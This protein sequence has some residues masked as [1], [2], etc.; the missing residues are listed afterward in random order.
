MA[1]MGR[2]Y[3]AT[4]R[5]TMR[6]GGEWPSLSYPHHL[7]HG[8]RRLATLSLGK[9]VEGLSELC[10][11][12]VDNPEFVEAQDLLKQAERVLSLA[13]DELLRKVQILGQTAFHDKLE[14]DTIFW[15]QCEKEWGRG[16]GYRIRVTDHNSAWFQAV[17]GQEI[18]NE[19]WEFIQK[20]W[21]QALARMTALLDSGH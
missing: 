3:V 6:R 18:E 13:Y 8:A 10:E 11:T 12:M 21:T 9:T 4:I 1:Q 20:E 17:R 7:G 16:S 14:K 5:A 19:L 15:T 2:V